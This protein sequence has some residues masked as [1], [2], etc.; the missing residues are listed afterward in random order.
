MQIAISLEALF[1]VLHDRILIQW[2]LCL[3]DL[4]ETEFYILVAYSSYFCLSTDFNSFA[5]LTS[6][7][8]PFELD[9]NTI[10]IFVYTRNRSSHGDILCLLG[11]VLQI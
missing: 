4:P 11:T 10:I 2:F 7:D 8:R 1:F 3:F 5:M 6:I 9:R